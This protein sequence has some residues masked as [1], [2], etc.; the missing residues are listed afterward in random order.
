MLESA[1][2]GK[3]DY[4]ITKSAKRVSKN[5]VELLQIMRYLKERS[6]SVKES[7]GQPKSG[8]LI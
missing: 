8:I 6:I 5:L 1:T 2:E 3:F 7:R 4:I